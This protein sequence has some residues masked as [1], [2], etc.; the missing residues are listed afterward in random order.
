MAPDRVRQAADAN[1]AQRIEEL[2]EL[3]DAMIDVVT[4][5]NT[6]LSLGLPAS[7][8][9]H[10]ETKTRLAEHFEL[11]V[12]EVAARRVRLPA[13]DPA[14]QAK[15]VGRIEC[16]R[17]SMDENMIRLRAAIEASQRRI[18]TVMAAIREQMAGA[19][20]YGA[21]GRIVARSA[22]SGTNLRA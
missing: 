12:G 3:I 18:E 20:P 13:G 19:S 10:T 7:Q 21:G 16:L 11:W 9:R 6:A 15:F 14:L 2:I 8:S 5:E 22:S 4:A 1:S 17:Q